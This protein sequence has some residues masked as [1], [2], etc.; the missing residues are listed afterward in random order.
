MAFTVAKRIV[1]SS[2]IM[3]LLTASLVVMEYQTLKSLAIKENEAGERYE[4]AAKIDLVSGIGADLYRVI[5][6]AEINFDMTATEK[7]WKEAKANYQLQMD[8]INKIRS[9]NVSEVELKAAETSVATV[10]AIFENE[11]L[12]E[13]KRSEGITPQIKA[14]DDKIDKSVDAV[15]KNFK[16]LADHAEKEAGKYDQLFDTQAE[17]DIHNAL[18]V[19]GVGALVVLCST[20]YL[21]RQVSKPIKAMTDVMT[22]LAQG[23][24]SAE[25]PSRDRKDEIG[26]MAAAVQVFKE[27]MIETERMRAEQEKMKAAAER[28]KKESMYR[29]AD[30]FERGLQGIVSTVAAAATELYQT[31]EEMS[32]EVES[33]DQQSSRVASTSQQTA[34]NVQSVAA[35]AEEMTA[36]VKEITAQIAK[37]MDAIRETVEKVDAA[38]QSSEDL[39]RAT[40]SIGSMA[41]TIESISGQINLLA[42]NATIES[43]RAGE[44]GKGFAVVASEVKNLASQ[45]QKSTEEIKTQV[46]GVQTVSS[47]VIDALRIIKDAVANVSS[48]SSAISAAVE[49]QSAVNQEVAKNMQTASNGVEMISQGIDS[50]KQ[51]VSNTS[52]STKQVLDAAKMLSQQSEHLS[53]EVQTFLETIRAA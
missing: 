37:S 7:D 15:E 2:L 53:R 6:D 39:T 14:L 20:I 16:T 24:T 31:A 21:V 8:E 32:K 9:D 34:A 19:L 30:E 40:D 44:A 18:M 29:L 3:Q 43:A 5:A 23:N 45:T 41:A 10:I 22:T 51:S 50:V 13:L 4:L 52:G 11:M 46:G 17:E 47:Q 36:S 26:N 28:E 42:L 25:I 27:N 33:A 12:P 1:V 48:F 49:E 38:N 35:A